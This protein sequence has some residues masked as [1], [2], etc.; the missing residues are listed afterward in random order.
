MTEHFPILL[1]L[2]P[3]L[4]AVLIPLL[5]RVHGSIPWMMTMLSSALAFL[6]SIALLLRVL[7]EGRISYWLGNW[8]PPWGIE[9]AV[10]YLNGFVLVVVS[11][12]ALM[13]AIYSRTSIEKEIRQFRHT[14]FYTLYMLLVAGLLGIVITGDIFNLY[15]FIEISSLAGY[16]LIA[17]GTREKAL[18]AS[19]NY[20]ILGTIGATFLI[21]GV[22]LL[23]MVTGTLNM[24]DL[25]ERLPELYESRV[26]LTAFAFFSVGLSLKMAL[27]PLH[28]WMPNAYTHAPSAV[29]AILA[30]ISTK[31][32]AYALIRIMF[33][34]FDVEFATSVSYEMIFIILASAGILAGSILAIAQTNLKTMLAYSSVAQIGYIVL[35][36]ALINETALTGSIMHILNHAL[37]KGALFLV[38]GAVVLRTGAEDISALRGLGRKMPFTMAAFTVASLSMIGVPL[39]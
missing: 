8:P 21:M 6:V 4:T 37:M 19:F 35:G 3:L 29:S 15:V 16:A 26:V 13:V 18:T 34:V 5:A 27:F 7:S 32:G 36:A 33:T 31:V 30:A 10:D 1:V 24:A 23:Y 39:T 20:L 2:V 17:S 9:Y 25:G 22:G 11:F 38:A 14:A 12:I 28:I